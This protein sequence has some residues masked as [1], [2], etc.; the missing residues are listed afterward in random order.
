ML[1]AA[2]HQP[3][4]LR[5]PLPHTSGAM[6]IPFPPRTLFA[7]RIRLPPSRK[8]CYPKFPS[9]RGASGPFWWPRRKGPRRHGHGTRPPP[10]A[11][12]GGVG[13]RT[14]PGRTRSAD[15]VHRPSFG[16]SVSRASVQFQL[17][18]VAGRVRVVASIGWVGAALAAPGAALTHPP[19]APRTCLLRASMMRV[20]LSIQI[21]IGHL[22]WTAKLAPEVHHKRFSLSLGARM[23][24]RG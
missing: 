14:G 24:F 10:T 18:V 7:S 15:V 2:L 1:A 5:G 23:S 12:G 3:P 21:N 13:R 8:P 9:R 19:S 22:V 4:P 6:A 17:G 20:R 11:V 16:T